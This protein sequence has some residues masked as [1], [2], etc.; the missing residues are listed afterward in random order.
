MDVRIVEERPNPLLHR[1]EYVFEVSHPTGPTPTRDAVRGELAKMTKVPKDR[2]VIERMNAKFGTATTLG[3]ATGYGDVAALKK[4]A[5]AHVLKRN[6]LAEKPPAPSEKPA[7][8]APAA[9]QGA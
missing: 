5:R 2:L 8:D 9:G 1:T 6:G 3:F 7:E 4:V